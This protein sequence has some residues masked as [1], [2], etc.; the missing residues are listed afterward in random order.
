MNTF[1]K[2]KLKENDVML[3][4][5]LLCAMLLL[6][7][8]GGQGEPYALPLFYAM[9]TNGLSLPVGCLFFLFAGGVTFSLE[10][11]I[12]YACQTLFLFSAF[13]IFRRLGGK[14]NYVYALF[15][16]MSLAFFVFLFPLNTYPILG[17]L[18]PLWQKCLVGMGIFLLGLFFQ[19]AIRILLFKFNRCRLSREELLHIAILLCTIGIGLYNYG[20]ALVYFSLALF[21]ILLFL[22]V[23]K[24]TGALVFAVLCALPPALVQMDI[25][26]LAIYALYAGMGLFFLPFGRIAS[27][28]SVFGVYA[29]EQLLNGIYTADVTEILLRILA[30]LMPCVAFLLLPSATLKRL[31]RRLV[32]YKD[33]Q[34]S[35]VAIN[36]NRSAVGERL[37][38]LSG[39]FRQIENTFS[40]LTEAHNGGDA[41][42]KE[43]IREQ[44]KKRL[45]AAC[46]QAEKC[47]AVGVDVAMEKLI[48]VGCAKGKVN[49]IDL[50]TLLS[51]HCVNAGGVL[52]CLNQQLAEYRKYM[53]EAEN[54]QSG[55]RL[56]AS[57]AQ[58][59]SELLK[60]IALEQSQALNVYDEKEKQLS[61]ALA[62]RGVVCSEILIYGEEENIAVNLTVF[63]KCENAKIVKAASE[64]LGMPLLTGEKLV[65]SSDKFCY[66]LRKKPNFDAAFGVASMKKYGESESGDTH[67][68]IR[69]DEKHFLC[70]LSDGMGS[71][72]N[73]RRISESA[74]SLLESFYR[75]GMPGSIVLSTVNKLLTFN[76]EESFAC[77]DLAAVDLDSGR[78]D[79]VK[80]GSPLGFIFSEGAIRVLEGEGLPMGMLED[81]RP[82]TLSVQLQEN[83]ILVFLSDGVT[84][85][86]GSSSDLFDYLKTLNPLN[87]QALADDIVKTAVRR[88]GGRAKDDMTALAV[89]IFQ[90][91]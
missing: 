8:V 70:A 49:L 34:L 41:G 3:Y 20:G 23:A 64:V 17:S 75:A 9:L 81:L 91:A 44:I 46:P 40:M 80:I 39:V 72:Q 87:P 90:A 50:P 43:H 89:R 58:G 82:T 15:L 2:L 22:G 4:G 60:N 5:G 33:N 59:I 62:K 19:S 67:S 78:A 69:I 79:V 32:F 84:D 66:T 56:M 57:Q 29:V 37:F 73:A 7:F 77:I 28:L 13:F 25:T 12:V 36:R 54:A 21:A 61:A 35:R 52:F 68:V 88:T 74:L 86:F 53:L 30:C 11:I 48:D 76:R 65:L 1:Q 63:G 71:G 85:A 24:S 18:P 47:R 27:V 6:T 16:L 10:K 83:D 31:E 55:R 26:V 45:C 14:N 42:A 38:A 51:S